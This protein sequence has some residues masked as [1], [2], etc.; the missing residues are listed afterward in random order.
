MLRWGAVALIPVVA[1]LLAVL[2]YRHL[3]R[4]S[5]KAREEVVVVGALNSTDSNSRHLCRSR[6]SFAGHPRLGVTSKVDDIGRGWSAFAGAARLPPSRETKG[7]AG[8]LALLWVV[9]T[10]SFS[11]LSGWYHRS[12]KPLLVLEWGTKEPSPGMLHLP[13][14]NIG[15]GR[16]LLTLAAR[17]QEQR[18]GWRWDYIIHIDEDVQLALGS[19]AGFTD[20]LHKWMPAVGVPIFGCKPHKYSPWQ[21][22]MEHRKNGTAWATA[23]TDHIWLAYRDDATEVLWPIDTSLD[24]QC[25]WSSQYMQSVWG[26]SYF[27]GHYLVDGATEV[28]NPRHD[29]Y[30][31]DL[32]LK[33]WCRVTLQALRRVVQV[34]GKRGAECYRVHPF[35]CPHPSSGGP[36]V[37]DACIGE[38]ET[39]L[40][41][42]QPPHGQ[43]ADDECAAYGAEH[44]CHSGDARPGH[45]VSFRRPVDTG[46]GARC[47][48]WPT[49]RWPW[50]KYWPRRCSGGMKELQKD[51][52]TKRM[53]AR[54]AEGSTGQHHCSDRGRLSACASWGRPLNR[55]TPRLR[56][57]R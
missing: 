15:Q 2:G 6:V 37:T 39:L 33:V 25:Y 28:E 31:R 51:L 53:K 8:K 14:S 7:C 42:S 12:L 57:P 40:R 54:E 30:P 52:Q 45:N 38:L 55:K 34:A 23:H 47:G 32:C 46:V 36:D 11:R 17:E 20:F 29:F 13:K 18:Q 10:K 4:E 35:L 1:V 16:N 41:T 44:V 27:P 49:W 22:C 9:Q 5:G 26:A 43:L 19:P 48:G 24:P 50:Q 21:K 3:L 56:P